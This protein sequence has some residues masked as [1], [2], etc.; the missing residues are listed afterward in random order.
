M[1]VDTYT[2]IYIYVYIYIIHVWGLLLRYGQLPPSLA[3]PTGW[4]KK[5]SAQ[6]CQVAS[7][8][9]LSSS[10]LTWIKLI[11]IHLDMDIIGANKTVH[12]EYMH[13]PQTAL[14]CRG[15][16]GVGQG[17]GLPIGDPSRSPRLNFCRRAADVVMV[18]SLPSTRNGRS[19]HFRQ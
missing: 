8:K 11:F 4:S 18:R 2:Y 6:L 7:H 9:S 5:A 1:Y 10:T 19:C 13:I 12:Q 3:S 15:S 17:P 14:G 16:L